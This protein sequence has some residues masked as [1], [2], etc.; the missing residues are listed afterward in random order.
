VRNTPKK[1]LFFLFVAVVGSA[2][3]RYG[4]A[5]AARSNLFDPNRHREE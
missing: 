1:S 2:T 4:S 5:W 3:S